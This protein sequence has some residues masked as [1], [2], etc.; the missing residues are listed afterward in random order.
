MTTD[1]YTTEDTVI[2]GWICLNLNRRIT[3]DPT[4]IMNKQYGWICDC[5]DKDKKPIWTFGNDTQHKPLDHGKRL[6]FNAQLFQQ[7]NHTIIQRVLT[8]QPE[9][10]RTDRRCDHCHLSVPLSKGREINDMGMW[11]CYDCYPKE[12][13][14]YGENTYY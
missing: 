10:A 3:V 6:I 8:A 13:T 4:A 14:P 7:D 12:K 5:V 11:I 9:H 1:T 2:V